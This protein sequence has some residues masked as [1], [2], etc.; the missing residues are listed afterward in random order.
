[1]LGFNYQMGSLVLG[2][3]GDLEATNARGGFK[4]A[5][6][7]PRPAFDPG[8]IVRVKQDWQGS[9]RARIGYAFDRFMIYGTGGVAFSEL[10]L[11]L[12]QPVRAARRRERQVL[13]HRL[14]RRR[15]R[16]LRHHRQHHPRPRLSLH[17]LRQLRLCRPQRLPRPDGRAEPDAPM[18]F[19]PASPT[20]S[21]ASHRRPASRPAAPGE[22]ARRRFAPRPAMRQKP[23]RWR[24]AAASVPS[25]R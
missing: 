9:V 25:S 17:R 24:I 22:A 18:R 8:G 23:V 16:Q 10:R 11:Q 14:D 21:D 6:G 20:S 15:R 13:A 4:D 3:E 2:V 1:M 19:A 5:G 12:F 7:R